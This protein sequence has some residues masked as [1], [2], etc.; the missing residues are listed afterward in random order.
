MDEID[1]GL[2]RWTARHPEWHPRGFG[3][4]V[5]S[6]AVQAHDDTTLLI[7]PLLPDGEH[8]A[9]IVLAALDGL[10]RENVAILISIP[11][12]A[13]SAKDLA[14]R[15]DATIYGHKACVKRLGSEER[16]SK[17]DP[18]EPL[19]ADVRAFQIG[20]PRRF[21]MPLFLPSHSAVVFGDSVVEVDGELRVWAQS[22]VD[23]DEEHRI[24]DRFVPTLQ[25]LV[26]LEPER[27][28]V[29]HGQPV[30]SGGAE[31]LARAMEREPFWHHG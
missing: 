23:A 6:F 31:E 2:W 21:E 16:F 20:K 29:T 10:T 3:D 14:E 15:Y 8:D 5:A 18:D 26:D 13:R 25:P 24:P 27:V 28:L 22:A 4:Q 12:H 9:A 7:D 19:A 30:L 1:E 11:Y 17:I